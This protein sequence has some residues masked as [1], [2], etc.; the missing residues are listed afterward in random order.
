MGGPSRKWLAVDQRSSAPF[1]RE[2]YSKVRPQSDVA[3]L[4]SQ[5]SES[6][7]CAYLRESPIC[8]HT[9]RYP[10]APEQLGGYFLIQAH[11][12]DEALTIAARIHAAA[13]GTVEVCPVV[14]I[15]N[16][17]KSLDQE[18]D[19]AAAGPTHS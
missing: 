2:R 13:K 19:L 4:H 8:R 7:A 10:E 6:S 9:G 16:L 5:R 3:L 15:P 18:V 11:D 12:S 1:I 17:P 14:E